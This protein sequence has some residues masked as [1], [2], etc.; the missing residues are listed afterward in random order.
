[1]WTRCGLYT[2]LLSKFSL[3]TI[4]KFSNPSPR[5]KPSWTRQSQS[6]QM[7]ET[8]IALSWREALN[9]E[10]TQLLNPHLS[11]LTVFLFSGFCVSL[12]KS[13]ARQSRLFHLVL[14]ADQKPRPTLLSTPNFS[15]LCYVFSAIYMCLTFPVCLI[16]S[17]PSFQLFLLD[18]CLCF[19]LLLHSYYQ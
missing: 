14:V 18:H 19:T 11:I 15:C 12:W 7:L 2:I 9:L 3:H 17:H 1:M 5:K 4:L 10:L 16:H 13:K 8:Y 6:F